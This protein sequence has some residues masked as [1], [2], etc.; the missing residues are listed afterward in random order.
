M[1]QEE[2]RRRSSNVEFA[3]LIAECVR[4]VCTA[5]AAC[6][7]S[8]TLACWQS[9]R[10]LAFVASRRMSEVILTYVHERLPPALRSKLCVYRGGYSKEER[11]DNH[12]T[13]KSQ[14][15]NSDTLMSA[16]ASAV[17]LA[18]VVAEIER[19]LRAGELLAV[20]GTSALE[21]GLDI[22]QID[23]TL[24][25]GLQIGG[26]ASLTQQM[27]RAGRRGQCAVHHLLLCAFCAAMPYV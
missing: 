26:V 14:L 23:A 7:E 6:N 10:T 5:A 15:N 22:G 17:D 20:L 2:E 3:A 12:L 27:G 8:E 4:H 13:S 21:L 11:G 18:F 16:T 25:L 24:H 1:R 19:R 9:V